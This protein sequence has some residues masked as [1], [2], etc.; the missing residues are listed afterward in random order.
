VLGYILLVDFSA[1][2]LFVQFISFCPSWYK[3]KN[4]DTRE[5]GLLQTLALSNTIPKH[6]SSVASETRIVTSVVVDISSSTRA[7]FSSAICVLARPVR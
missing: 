7:P 1:V 3:F 4:F 6:N 2:S 5:I